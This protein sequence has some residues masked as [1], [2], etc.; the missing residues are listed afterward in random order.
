MKDPISVGIITFSHTR[1]RE[2]HRDVVRNSTGIL[3]KT[4]IKTIR[5]IN[6][7]NMVKPRSAEVI[8]VSKGTIRQVSYVID[9][10]ADNPY[11]S[12]IH[13]GYLNTR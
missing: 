1:E 10:Q 12:S 5:N 4:F 13:Q 6:K 7:R 3:D 9:S 2:G 8:T 11:N